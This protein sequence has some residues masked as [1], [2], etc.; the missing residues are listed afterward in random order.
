[1]VKIVKNPGPGASVAFWDVDNTLYDDRAYFQAGREAE[2]LAI[3]K[4]LG[5]DVE[6]SR[7]AVEGAKERLRARHDSVYRPTLTE[8]VF[9]LGLDETWWNQVRS[10][11][12]EPERYL[13][14]DPSVIQAMVQLGQGGIRSLA[15][16]NSPGAL[17]RRVIQ[18]LGLKERLDLVVG[19][20]DLGIA[21]HDSRYFVRVCERAG[22]ERGTCVAIGDRQATDIDPPLRL[23][24]S[25]GILVESAKD[26]PEVVRLLLEAIR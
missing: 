26:V 20:D 18:A 10:D 11:C 21:K 25:G 13:K 14:P 9:E 15:A 22:V 8:T 12:Y 16:S 4:A 5:L 24:F 23:G 7:L 17:T 6:A 1:M 2:V 3:A 19:P